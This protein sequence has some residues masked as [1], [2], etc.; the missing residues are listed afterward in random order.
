M[1]HTANIQL[2]TFGPLSADVAQRLRKP[3]LITAVACTSDF[4]HCTPERSAIFRTYTGRVPL[5][6]IAT[7]IGGVCFYFA[8]NLTQPEARDFLEG[9]ADSGEFPAVLSNRGQMR[10]YTIEL[11]EECLQINEAIWDAEDHD[12]ATSTEWSNACQTLAKL[13]LDEFSEGDEDLVDHGM[14]LML[15]DRM[16]HLRALASL[17]GK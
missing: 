7:L 14:V 15:P 12:E 4:H 17:A 16:H 8:F 11:F 13:L 10:T 3:D 2:G 5:L 6:V 1:L 9:V